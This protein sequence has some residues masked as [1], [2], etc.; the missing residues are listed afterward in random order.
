VMNLKGWGVR[1]S[2]MS[3]FGGLRQ[4]DITDITRDITKTRVQVPLTTIVSL[5]E[6]LNLKLL[7]GDYKPCDPGWKQLNCKCYFSIS[8][9]TWDEGRQHCKE[10]GGD[11]AV[12]NR[13][14][15]EQTSTLQV[16]LANEKMNGWIGLTD[17][18]NEG[19]WT[20]VDSSPLTQEFWA[21]GQP[22]S[23]GGLDEDCAVFQSDAQSAM[24]S[25]HDYECSS[26]HAAI[27]E[28]FASR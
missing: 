10:K 21:K 20:W 22:D 7:Q 6:T 25:W 5:S 13:S 28:K 26:R 3:W 1:C 9:V 19:T 14:R 16:L 12:I 11:L 2:D 23:R 17:S 15:E 4:R 18:K 8:A 24:S 27:C